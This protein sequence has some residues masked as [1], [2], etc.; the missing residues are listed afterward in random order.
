MFGFFTKIVTFSIVLFAFVHPG[1]EKKHPLHVSTTE[2]NHN[3]R[4]KTVEITAAIFTDDFEDILRRKYKQKTD[5]MN[6]DF[7]KK[8]DVLVKNYLV[9]HLSVKLDGKPYALEY[10]GFEIDHEATN[11]YLQI[12]GIA[13]FTDFEVSDTILHDLFDDQMS[14]VHV[15][16]NGVR[17]SHKLLFPDHIF[18][19]RF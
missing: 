17:K 6:A 10:V 18:K 3:A 1:L 11:V 2:F 8:M 15:I 13:G 9:S 19:V 14:I 16:R 4:E 5:L 7:H 12:S